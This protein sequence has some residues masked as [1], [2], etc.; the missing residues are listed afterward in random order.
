[1]KMDITN[2]RLDEVSSIVKTMEKRGFDSRIERS[3][4]Q[5]MLIFDMRSQRP[6]TP[7]HAQAQSLL[8]W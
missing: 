5:F 8:N 6:L 1:M 7:M 4:D 2:L 3:E